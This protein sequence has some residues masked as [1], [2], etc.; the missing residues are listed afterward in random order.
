MIIHSYSGVVSNDIAKY[1]W[2][3]LRRFHNVKFVEELHSSLLSIPNKYRHFATKQALQIRHCLLQA[4]E[5]S[6]AARRASLATKPVLL[7]YSC[8][9]L[10]YAEILMKQ[11]GDSSLDRARQTDNHHGLSLKVKEKCI[12]TADNFATVASPMRAV[13]AVRSCGSRFGTFELWRKSARFQPTIG[14]HVIWHPDMSNTST[15]SIVFTPKDEA[16]EPV[17]AEGLSLLDALSRVAGLA[18]V[19]ASFGYQHRLIRARLERH[20]QAVP[21]PK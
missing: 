14:R 12:A 18:D 8:L 4:W 17:P 16:L 15:H 21:V 13:P 6:E 19:I 20:F 10:A 2:S 1:S 11:D 9:S 3:N 7:Y 5:Y